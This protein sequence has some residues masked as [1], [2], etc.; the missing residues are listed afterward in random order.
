MATTKMTT[1]KPLGLV[2]ECDGRLTAGRDNGYFPC[3]VKVAWA[4]TNEVGSVTTE[5]GA[6]GGRRWRSVD[7]LTCFVVC[8]PSAEEEQLIQ[9]GRKPIN[10]G[11]RGGCLR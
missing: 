3:G 10:G 1:G 4:S 9:G 5:Y 2:Y 7:L 11:R 8:W 6:N